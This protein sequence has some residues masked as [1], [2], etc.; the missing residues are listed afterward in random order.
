M[1]SII[2]LIVVITIFVAACNTKPTE[3]TAE[4]IQAQNDSIEKAAEEKRIFDS[5]AMEAE[6]EFDAQ[7]AALNAEEQKLKEETD[8]LTGNDKEEADKLWNEYIEILRDD[9]TAA[10]RLNKARAELAKLVE[11]K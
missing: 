2:L 11:K 4:Q 3:P 10:E 9:S 1:K 7:L 6:K 5:I 8:R